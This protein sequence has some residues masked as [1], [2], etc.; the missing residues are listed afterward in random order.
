MASHYYIRHSSIV[1]F[2]EHLKPH[3]GEADILAMIALSSGALAS[4][5]FLWA[6][7]A[8]VGLLIPTIPHKQWHASLLPTNPPVC[9][10]PAEFENLAVRDEELPELDTLVREACPYEVKGG[11]ENKQGKANVLLQVGVSGGPLPGRFPQV[12]APA[13]A[14]S[15]SCS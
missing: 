15:P 9:R 7:L 2:N 4:W 12:P 13:P 8:W 3:M 10:L 1:V 6:V 14:P 11:S 5:H